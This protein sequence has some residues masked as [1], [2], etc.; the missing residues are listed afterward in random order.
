MSARSM[1][2]T[3]LDVSALAGVAVISGAIFLIA[4][5][6]IYVPLA[7]LTPVYPFMSVAW[8]IIYGFW[9]IGGTAAAYIIRKPGAAF[10][11]EFL[12]ALVEMVLGSFFG[13]SVI[14]WGILQAISSEIGFAIWRYKRWDYV[15]M[16]VAGFLPGLPI[17]IPGW[18][19]YPTLYISVIEYGGYGALAAFILLHSISG[20]IIAGI[21][22]KFFIDRI[23]RTGIFDLFEIGKEIKKR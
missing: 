18:F 23:A 20:L 1:R 16:S 6:Y 15:S 17:N 12:G 22:T 7:G 8:P 2:Y 11:G 3:A 14:I 21:L 19:L 9:F 10:F 5:N 4:S 13:I